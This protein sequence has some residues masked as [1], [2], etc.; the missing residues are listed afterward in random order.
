[1]VGELATIHDALPLDRVMVI[2]TFGSPE[3]MQALVRYEGGRVRKVSP[4]DRLAGGRVISVDE[5]GLVLEIKGQS[6]RLDLL[7]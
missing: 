1:M 7:G 4:G 6:A 2:G 5:A 3:A